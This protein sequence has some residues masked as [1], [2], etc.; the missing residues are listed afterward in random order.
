M[1]DFYFKNFNSDHCLLILPER[2]QVVSTFVGIPGTAGSVDGES[3]V[4]TIDFLYS[5]CLNNSGS[6][7][8]IDIADY[9]NFTY[10]RART[11]DGY[12]STLAGTSLV[13]G[14]TD[15]AGVDA[16]FNTPVAITSAS[17]SIF[18]SDYINNTVRKVSS[19][20]VVSTFAGSAGVMGSTDGTGSVARFNR[21]RD[22][23]V[24]GDNIFVCDGEN[25]TIR[26][27]TLS[28][29][30]STFAGSAG[31][32]GSTD[33][34]GSAASFSIIRGMCADP[35]GN[36][37][38][39]DTDNNTIRKI[40]PDGEV[41]TI[42]GLAGQSGAVDGVGSSARFNFPRGM[43]HD[44]GNT[45][46]LADSD[47][48][49]VRKINTITYDVTTFVG[50]LGTPGDATGLPTDARLNTPSSITGKDDVI[51][52]AD[53][54]NYAIRKVAYQDYLPSAMKSVSRIPSKVVD[55][56][57]KVGGIEV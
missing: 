17:G 36:I 52:I 11:S 16:L 9:G 45:I 37:Y 7:E 57:S 50:S 18:I 8:Y 19:D 1:S 33:G 25:Y 21:L 29:M 35:V 10:R 24:V 23:T 3:G 15:G 12:L 56:G 51:Y 38:V 28:G 5:I 14:S 48:H 34:S 22:I 32:L 4:G 39:S 46:Y 42:A 30:V 44:G 26:K 40:T 13:S 2:V 41:T 49:A 31:V 6:E 47:N 54:L 53:R 27:I 20:N 55:T 43:W